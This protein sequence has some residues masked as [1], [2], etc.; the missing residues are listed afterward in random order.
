[1]PEPAFSR[2][3]GRDGMIRAHCPCDSRG[4]GHLNRSNPWLTDENKHFGPNSTAG[5]SSDSTERRF[6]SDAGLLAFREL[7]EAFRL[8]ENGSAV[9]SDAR[10]RKNT[11]HT[12]LAMLRQSAYGHLAGYE[13]ANDAERLRIDLAMRRVVRGCCPKTRPTLVVRARPGLVLRRNGHR[14]SSPRRPGAGSAG[15]SGETGVVYSDEGRF[16]L[17]RAGWSRSITAR[18]AINGK[19]RFELSPHQRNHR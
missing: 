16:A 13:D 6:T 10:Y 7:N 1:M 19:C 9:L 15:W 12:L 3:I 17:N 18:G 14:S 11:Q 4:S 8:T 2:W 5:S